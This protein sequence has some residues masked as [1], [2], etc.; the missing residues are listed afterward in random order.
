[1]R[2]RLLMGSFRYALLGDKNKP[3]Y[4]RL[5]NIEKRI[6][7]YKETGNDELLVDIANIALCEFVEGEHPKKH[8]YAEDDKNHSTSK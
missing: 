7:V 3:R 8:F 2:N 6:S 1:M 5:A 4:D